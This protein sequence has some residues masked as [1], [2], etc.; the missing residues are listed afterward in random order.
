M[1]ARAATQHADEREPRDIGSLDAAN[2]VAFRGVSASPLRRFHRNLEGRDFVVGDIHGHFDTVRRLLDRVAFDPDRDRLFGVG[3][4]VNRGPKS[5]DVLHWISQPWYAQVR[6]NHEQRVIEG[7]YD[8]LTRC[9]AEWFLSLAPG[10]RERHVDVLDRLPIAI[11]IQTSGLPIG[12]CHAEVP[13]DDW[14]QFVGW[15]TGETRVS[16]HHLERF[17]LW[18]R[19]IIRG[20]SAFSGVAGA[21]RIFVGHTIVDRVTAIENVH[22]IDLGARNGRAVCLYEIEERRAFVEPCSS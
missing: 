3:D 13:G 1:T 19:D 8:S 5:A 18:G 4:A 17:A 9:G 15:L 20:K 21:S 16:W 14:D 7:S 12:I 11:E 22:Y 10:E 2:T 6:G